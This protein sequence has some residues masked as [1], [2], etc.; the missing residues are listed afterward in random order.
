MTDHPP[1][2]HGMAAGACSAVVARF[3]TY[4]PDTVK[5]RIQLQGSGKFP[6]R[7]SG[8]RDA[9]TKIARR[10]G[11]S[12][13]YRGYLSIVAT[14]IP[15]NACYFTSYEYSKRITPPGLAGDMLT[16]CMAQ[17]VAGIVFCPIDILKQRVQT[18]GLE[19][20]SHKITVPQA[21]QH[22]MKT[23]GIAGFY[24]GFITMNALWLPWNCIYLTLYEESKRR[25][26]YWQKSSLALDHHQQQS[27]SGGVLTD[28]PLHEVLPLWAFPMCSS[29]CAVIASVVTHPI[30]VVKTRLQV[31]TAS[32]QNSNGSSDNSSK[33][34]AR[35]VART[36]FQS[37]GLKGFTRGMITRVSTIG[38]GSTVSWGTYELIKRKLLT[39]EADRDR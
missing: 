22:I 21:A 10:E 19:A 18:Q 9:F 13:F 12:G 25:V 23:Q 31:L 11:I 7:Y 34:T 8:T 15:A 3:L 35:Q 38:F 39:I 24:R 2:W 29:T 28:P 37:E 20:A 33:L 6:V 1:L 14:V 27:G 17:T 26:Y 16:A 4:P 30:D 32:S 5:A 36:L